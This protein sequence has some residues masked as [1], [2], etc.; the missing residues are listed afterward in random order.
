MRICKFPVAGWDD[1]AK[2]G[3]VNVDLL[4]AAIIEVDVI[5]WIILD[6]R[7]GMAELMKQV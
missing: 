6:I 3:V 4:Y 1:R 5:R 2:S 7:G